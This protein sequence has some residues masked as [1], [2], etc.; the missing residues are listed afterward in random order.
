MYTHYFFKYVYINYRM[1]IGRHQ[2]SEHGFVQN[3]EKPDVIL[4]FR[5]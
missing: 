2:E 1:K 5:V 4:W 3:S